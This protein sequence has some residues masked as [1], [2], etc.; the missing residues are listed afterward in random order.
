MAQQPIELISYDPTAC[1]MYPQGISANDLAML[2]PHVKGARK[3]ALEDLQL[4]HSGDPVPKHKQPLDA[5]FM[6]LPERLL[7]AY[8]EQG[9]KSE[10]GQV[11]ACAKRVQGLVDRVVV[12]GIGGSYMGAKALFEGCCHPYHNDL[13]RAARTQWA[14][15]QVDKPRIYFEGNNLDNDAVQG[16]LDLLDQSGK[17]DSP[18]DSWAIVVI[19]KSGTTLETAIAFRTLLAAL[20]KHCGGDEAKVAQRVVAVT[21]QTNSRLR[22][23][24]QAMKLPDVFDVPEG[25]GGRF[26]IFSPVGLLPAAIMGLDVV[27]LL[28][29]AAAMNRVFREA[30]ISANPVL[31]YVSVCQLLEQLQG[32]HL[33]VLSFW[34]KGMESSGLWY[35]QLLSE[36]LGKGGRGATPLTVVNTRD[37]HS[38]GQQ[39]QEGRRDKLITNVTVSQCQR[40]PL[41]VGHSEL[42]QDR[43]NSLSQKSYSQIMTAAIDGTN[44]GYADDRRPTATLHLPLL[45]EASLG[46]FYQMLMLATVVEGRLIGINPYGQPGVEVYK[47]HMNSNLRGKSG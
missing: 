25:V 18:E 28:E 36:S 21:G 4:W 47:G 6:D 20:R 7:A 12:L 8:Q 13:S 16:L 41:R 9:E 35:D 14:P 3:E 33:R 17:C 30:D 46:Q 24:A 27:R 2:A 42:D 43:L 23:L 39:H 40:T 19:S 45:D 10:L 1:M 15:A 34:G 38:R 31:S 32:C 44:Q 11:L 22:E 37:L 29:G 26:S 5:G